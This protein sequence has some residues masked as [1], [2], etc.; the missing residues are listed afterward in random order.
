MTAVK[1]FITQNDCFK[2]AS[3]VY[4]KGIV[5]HSTGSNNPYL[6]RYVQ[7]SEDDGNKAELTKLIG[8]NQHGNSWNRSGVTKAVHYM[9]GKLADDNV[10]TLYILPEE[11]SCWGVGKGS[12]GSYN[13][14]PQAHI[15]FEICE[16]DLYGE[17]YF[18][19]VYKEATELCADICRRYGWDASVIVSHKEAHAQ[20]YGS[21]HRDVD[22]WLAIYGLKMDDFRNEVQRILD[23]TEIVPLPE[24]SFEHY[25][26]E[27]A[28][29][30]FKITNADG[31]VIGRLNAGAKIK[32]IEEKDDKYIIEALVSKS[33][34]KER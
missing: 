30:P 15:Q 27:V 12:K 1:C 9:I 31:A 11:Y 34:F 29:D 7:P 22:H 17:S 16:D 13:Y 23:T 10:G 19:A 6:K 3:K 28:D 32:V 21:N 2:E 26:A 33:A 24:D 20:G 8:V 14:A 4:Q 5:V 25:D 18:K